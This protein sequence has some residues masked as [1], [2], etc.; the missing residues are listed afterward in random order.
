MKFHAAGKDETTLFRSVR[1]S[2][3]LSLP[4]G[5]AMYYTWKIDML[6]RAGTLANGKEPLLESIDIMWVLLIAA[7]IK[8]IFPYVLRFLAGLSLPAP[9]GRQKHFSVPIGGVVLFLCWLPF[10]LAFY[11]AA[12]MNDTVYIVNHPLRAVVQFPW[13]Y[14]LVEGG[15]AS[16]GLS[17]TDSFEGV[18]FSLSLVQMA[19]SAWVLAWAA[20][21]TA[22]ITGRRWMGLLLVAYFALFP[23]VGNYAAAAVKDTAYGLFLFLWMFYFLDRAGGREPS[24]FRT[25]GLLSGT[26]LF[27]NNGLPTAI[28]LG[29]LSIWKGKKKTLTAAALVGAALLSV[30]PSQVAYRMVGEEPLFQESAAVPLQQMG[31]VFVTGGDMTAEAKTFMEAILPEEDWRSAYSPFTVD[32]VKWHDHFHRDTLNEKKGDFLRYWWETGLSNPRLYSEAWMTETYALWN[33]DPLEHQVQSRFGWALTDENTKDMKPE[34]NDMMATGDFPMAPSLKSALAVWQYEGSRFLGAGL[35]FWLALLACLV[36]FVQKRGF[37]A[38]AGLPLF[39][40]TAT[41]LLSTPASSV[42]RYSFAYV[43]GLPLLWLLVFSGKKE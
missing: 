2:E 30:I 39:I 23:M 38:L 41:L 4:L 37:Y 31:R 3:A 17:M 8:G 35:S 26:A 42:F 18:L 28:I 19:L 21:K 16:A 14:C 6:D 40:N 7:A 22:A 24:T 32:F 34:N 43:L 27:R 5:A 1:A 9:L 20:G 29:L 25:A 13:L 15:I 36:L 33:L 12:G 11:P 10:L